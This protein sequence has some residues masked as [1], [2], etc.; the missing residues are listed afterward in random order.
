[1]KYNLNR[2]LDRVAA[3]KSKDPLGNLAHGHWYGYKQT[4]GENTLLPG[5]YILSRWM[6]PRIMIAHDD[7]DIA[8][9]IAWYAEEAMKRFEEEGVHN[10]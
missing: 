10:G 5:E 7:P 1:M 6:K 9:E 8:L 4:Y 2:W 3:E